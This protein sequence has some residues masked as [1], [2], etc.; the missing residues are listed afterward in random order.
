MSTINLDMLL[1]LGTVFHL[2]YSMEVCDFRCSQVIELVTQLICS[3][4]KQVT[5]FINTIIESLTQ[6][7]IWLKT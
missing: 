5:V 3:E 2:L 4:M 7:P 1:L 6:Q